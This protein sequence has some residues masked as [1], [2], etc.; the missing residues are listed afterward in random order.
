[1]CSSNN[2][3]Q[4]LHPSVA[5]CNCSQLQLKI[6]CKPVANHSLICRW[7]FYLQIILPSVNWTLICTLILDWQIELRSADNPSTRSSNVDLQIIC[8]S[9]ERIWWIPVFQVKRKKSF[10][11][12]WKVKRFFQIE[13][14]IKNPFKAF[15]LIALWLHFSIT[16]IKKEISLQYCRMFILHLIVCY[17]LGCG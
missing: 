15:V 1:M 6:S 10:E 5:N 2:K 11:D 8:W 17:T 9:V 12:R 7:F 14:K 3:V 13:L 4:L 16:Y